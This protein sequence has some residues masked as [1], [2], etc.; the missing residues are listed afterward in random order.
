MGLHSKPRAA[1]LLAIRAVY[2]IQDE[3]Q[4]CLC[5]TSCCFFFF[6]STQFHISLLDFVELRITTGEKSI[7]NSR[8]SLEWCQWKLIGFSVIIESSPPMKYW[9]LWD[10]IGR[11]PCGCR[12]RKSVKAFDISPISIGPGSACLQLFLALPFP[13]SWARHQVIISSLLTLGF[14]S[15][16]PE[17][18]GLRT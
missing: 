14:P 13:L 16:S 7:V 12:I 3:G 17:A 6:F 9:T 4:I 2:V 11:D 1:Q 15:G 5:S 10:F 18:L 8:Y